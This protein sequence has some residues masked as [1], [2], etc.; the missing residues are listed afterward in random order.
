MSDPRPEHPTARVVLAWHDALERADHEAVLGLSDPEVE[1]VGPRGSGH[2]HALLRRWLENA[3]VRL[4]PRRLFARGDLMVVEQ[5]GTWRDPGTGEPIGEAE[6]AS[7]FRVREGRVA[8]YAR[9]D[10]LAAALAHAGLANT[11]AL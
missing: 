6:V 2:G 7:V 11:D 1:I 3:R 8:L 5:H 4:E 10:D 9:F